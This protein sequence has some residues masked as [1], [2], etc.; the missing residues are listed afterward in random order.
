MTYLNFFR[1]FFVC[2][3]NDSASNNAMANNMDNHSNDSRSSIEELSRHEL[4]SSPSATRRIIDS[5]PSFFCGAVGSPQ[6]DLPYILNVDEIHEI[7]Y[8]L[9]K[10]YQSVVLDED[11]LSIIS[12]FVM[13]EW[14]WHTLSSDYKIEPNGLTI[15][16]ETQNSSNWNSWAYTDPFPTTGVSELRVRI[17]K[18]R[19]DRG[20]LGLGVIRK[21]FVEKSES[22]DGGYN[23]YSQHS[24]FI[25]PTWN[26]KEPHF[27]LK[28]LDITKQQ[29]MSEGDEITIVVNNNTREVHFY[30]NDEVKSFAEGNWKKL[31]YEPL[32]GYAILTTNGDQFSIV[33]NKNTRSTKFHASKKTRISFPTVETLVETSV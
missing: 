28:R 6:R 19:S 32:C 23:V 16:D 29:N 4:S 17:D 5:I 30:L 12:Q 18:K 21:S 9:A 25:D 33:Q 20:W 1:R 14:Q 11:I 2:S 13:N 22:G 27:N 26:A 24:I 15:I 7:L 10:Q 31:N 8:I 3:A